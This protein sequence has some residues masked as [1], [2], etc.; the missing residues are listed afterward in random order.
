MGNWALQVTMS[1]NPLVKIWAK[2]LD[3]CRKWF[4]V[5][6]LCNMADERQTFWEGGER[7]RKQKQRQLTCQISYGV[8]VSKLRKGF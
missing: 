3:R 5:A 8:Y 6:H 2:K 4:S 7:G 1:T